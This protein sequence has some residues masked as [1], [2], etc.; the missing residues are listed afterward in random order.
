MTDGPLLF[1]A[2]EDIGITLI[3]PTTD[4][5][6]S[7]TLECYRSGEDKIS[8]ESSLELRT[9]MA[10]GVVGKRVYI[11]HST[12]SS[13]G[14]DDEEWVD[15]ELLIQRQLYLLHCIAEVSSVF[16]SNSRH[17]LI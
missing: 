12:P 9:A 8:E 6:C 1:T 13:N 4:F 15:M 2:G 17:Q 3:E 5:G 14:S 7:F 16:I 11:T 10:N